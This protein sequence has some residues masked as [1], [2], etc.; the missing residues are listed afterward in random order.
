ML[1][2][3]SL[4][5]LLVLIGALVVAFSG[6][7]SAEFFTCSQRP[8][9]LLYSYSGTP[10]QYSGRRHSYSA[11]RAYSAPRRYSRAS[12]RYYR[13]GSSRYRRHASYYGG[14]RYWNGR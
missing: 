9:Q 3:P 8:G 7:A 14:A 11:P 1:R 2:R 10:G 4:F 13:A 12:S 5:G 6:P